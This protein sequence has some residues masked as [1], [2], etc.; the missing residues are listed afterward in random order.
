MNIT[1]SP[2]YPRSN[3]FIEHMAQTVKITQEK[4]KQ[5]RIDN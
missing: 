4:A 1:S 3:G 2:R 5:S